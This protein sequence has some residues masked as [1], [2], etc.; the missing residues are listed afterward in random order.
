[1]GKGLALPLLLASKE[2]FKGA[3]PL[4]KITPPGFL[5]ALL[6]QTKP[7]VI[8]TS[9]DD[10][11]GYLRDVK[12][13]YRK[14]VPAGQTSTTDDCSIQ[15]KP[16]YVDI[17][18]P[19]TLF[20]K[21]SIFLEDADVASFEKDALALQTIGTP[22]SGIVK[23]MM[24]AIMEAANG[25][26]ADINT[27]LL[28]LQVATFGK[29]VVSG[30]NAARTIN[31]PLSTATNP[32]NEGMTMVMSDAMLNEVRLD[33]P[34]IVG[35]GLVNNYYLNQAATK[36]TNDAG[37]F[38][39]NLA[40][41][42][43]YFDP[44]ASASWGANQFGLFEKDSIQFLNICRFRGPKAGMRGASEFGT[45]IL[46][47]SDSLGNAIGSLEFDWQKRIIDCPT[48]VTIGAGDPQTVGR[49]TVIDLMCSYNMLN[50]PGDSYAADDRLFGNN[51]TFRY[52]ATN[53]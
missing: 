6:G 21:Y 42:K 23:E 9:K 35:S 26:L 15:A 38:T 32:L 39:P 16:A 20:R 34:F 37:L 14:R 48:E 3:T 31:F 43:F 25:V 18:V 52:T 13:R 51:G 33:G 17:T 19:S 27:D 8:S 7:N 46:P 28:A 44:Y 10:G 5:Q 41:P 50:I 45:I 49:G 24:E 36:G 40:L 22:A 53:A 1:M 47:L 12:I 29:N 2:A 30:S 11:S 4:G